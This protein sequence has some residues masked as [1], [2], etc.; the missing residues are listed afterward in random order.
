MDVIFQSFLQYIIA[1]AAFMVIRDI[2]K[3]WSN[4]SVFNIRTL[5]PVYI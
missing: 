5:S 4:N 3:S 1:I 2:H